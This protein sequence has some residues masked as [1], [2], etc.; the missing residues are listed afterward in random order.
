MGVQCGFLDGRE[1]GAGC[2][3]L[4]RLLALAV[5]SIG[6]GGSLRGLAAQLGLDFLLD[7]EQVKRSQGIGA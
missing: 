7:D 5:L 3:A 2:F 6:L 1:T 4:S